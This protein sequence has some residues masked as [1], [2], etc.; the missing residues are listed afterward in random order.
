MAASFKRPYLHTHWDIT[1]IRQDMG[2]THKETRVTGHAS[3]WQRSQQDSGA[4]HA[5]YREMRYC[6]T[7]TSVHSLGP[8]RR[9]HFH[10]VAGR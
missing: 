3:N 4:I 9:Q 10:P 1:A 7:L 6:L 5:I 8:T 2:F